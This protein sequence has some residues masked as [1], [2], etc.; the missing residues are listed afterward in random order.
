M[1]LILTV[2]LLILN[3]PTH[4]FIFDPADDRL[5]KYFSETEINILVNE[6]FKELPQVPEEIENLLKR[7]DSKSKHNHAI[8]L[9]RIFL[10]L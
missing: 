7:I 6:D 2:F 4:S 9:E 8:Y 10:I 1:H 5:K 3:S